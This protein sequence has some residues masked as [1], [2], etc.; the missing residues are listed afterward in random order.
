MISLMCIRAGT[1]I[2]STPP[3]YTCPLYARRTWTSFDVLYRSSQPKIK[4]FNERISLKTLC[5]SHIQKHVS[6]HTCRSYLTM[7]LVLDGKLQYKSFRHSWHLLIKPTPTRLSLNLLPHPA[8]PAICIYN[9]AWKQDIILVL[10]SF[11]SKSD[12][13]KRRTS[14]LN[15]MGKKILSIHVPG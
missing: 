10:V 1:A 13:T 12:E 7:I 5:V 3:L 9:A 6:K 11:T 8:S 4:E 14:L 2:C 15:E